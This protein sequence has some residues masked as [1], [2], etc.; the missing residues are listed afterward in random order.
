[1]KKIISYSVDNTIKIWEM[2]SGKLS[3][4]LER[5]GFVGGVEFS[6]DKKKLISYYEIIMVSKFG[7]LILESYPIALQTIRSLD[8]YYKIKKGS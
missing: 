7:T 3:N 4:T 5:F 8:D 6:K 2:D 1:M